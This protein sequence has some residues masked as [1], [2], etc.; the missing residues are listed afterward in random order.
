MAIATRRDPHRRRAESVH[1]GAVPREPNTQLP[2]AFRRSHQEQSHFPEGSFAAIEPAGEAGRRS[3]ALAALRSG[4]RENGVAKKQRVQHYS[5]KSF[6]ERFAEP[7][8]KS[9]PSCNFCSTR[10]T[11]K[12][13]ETAEYFLQT[14]A[15][16]VCRFQGTSSKRWEPDWL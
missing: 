2:R 11:F 10:S 5:C 9:T 6:A 1:P 7:R 4:V 16:Q 12:Q 3:P 15:A 14:Q 8:G 13:T